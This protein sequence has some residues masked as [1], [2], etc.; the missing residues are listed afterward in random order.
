VEHDGEMVA[1]RLR[2]RGKRRG[3]W[4]AMHRSENVRTLR[5]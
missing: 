3:C 1:L 4:V 2:Q 5:S